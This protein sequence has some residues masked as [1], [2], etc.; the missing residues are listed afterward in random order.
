MQLDY[1]FGT[2]LQPVADGAARAAPQ[3]HGPPPRRRPNRHAQHRNHHHRQLRRTRGAR[4]IAAR[5]RAEL[6]PHFPHVTDIVVLRAQERLCH[7]GQ[8]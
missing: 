8:P 6:L 1:Q 2:D 3:L 5:A 4:Q 7:P